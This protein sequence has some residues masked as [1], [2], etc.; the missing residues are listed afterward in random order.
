MSLSNEVLK[1]MTLDEKIGQL[2]FVWP[3]ALERRTVDMTVDP[4]V[5]KAP[6]EEQR[7]RDKKPTTEISDLQIA[8]LKKYNVGGIAF[9]GYNIENR[10]Q[11]INY[12][13]DFMTSFKNIKVNKQSKYTRG[14]SRTLD[15]Y[16]INQE[17]KRKNNHFLH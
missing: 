13:H 7:D 17:K 14:I 4:S 6:L 15:I 9:F 11:V 10:E 5:I 12:I 1:Q 2:F 8:N 16:R 3:E